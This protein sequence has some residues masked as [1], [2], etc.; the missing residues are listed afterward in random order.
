MHR[1]LAPLAAAL[2][3]AAAPSAR[4][5][6][7]TLDGATSVHALMGSPIRV[8]VEGPPDAPVSLVLD[9]T[10]GPTVV[11]GVSVPVGFSPAWAAVPV[12][13]L[14]ADGRLE[15]LVHAPSDP[16]F[17]QRTL[18]A[19]AVVFDPVTPGAFE[20]SNGVSL[21]LKDRDVQLAGRTLGSAPGFEYVRAFQEG[22]VVELALDTARYPEVVGRTAD[23]YLMAARSRDAWIADVGLDTAL[24]GPVT[25]E[26][27]AGPLAD[28]TLV[29]DTG[30]LSGDAGD[31]LGVGYDVVLDLNRDG[32]FNGD[33]LMDGY[34]DESG[35]YVVDDITLPGPHPVT[36]VIYSGGSWLGQD[37]YYPTD[38]D[39][40]GQLPLVV[41]SHGNGH[42]FQW[43]DHIGNHLASYGYIVMSHE[44]R[45]A[46]G[47]ESASTTTLTNTDYFLGN[48]DTIAGGVLDGH[49]DSSRITWIGHSRGGE[50]VVRAFDRVFDGDWV[51]QHFT[52]FDIALISSIAP[53]GFLGIGKSHPHGVDYHLWTGV[54]DSDVNGC[55][56]SDIAQT[57]QLHDRASQRRM[58]VSLYGV[59]HGGFH[60]G[61]GSL[62][63]QGP[64][65]LT[66]PQTHRFMRGYLLPLVKHVVDGNIPAKD[67][68]WRQWEGFRPLGAPVNPCLEVNLQYREG[69]KNGTYVVDDH[70]DNDDDPTLSSC[71]GAVVAKGIVGYTEGR[72][73][74]A[75]TDFTHDPS[76]PWN[77]FTY[78]RAAG[79]PRQSVFEFPGDATLEFQLPAGDRD[80]RDHAYLSFRACQATRHPYTDAET[81][82]T[83]FDVTLRDGAGRTSTLSIDAWGGG[84]E[85]PWPRL[86]CGVGAGWAN[87][88][89]TIR[90]RLTDFLHV[91]PA[92]DLGDLEA[93]VFGFGPS[94][95]SPVG[96]LGFDDV[97]LTVD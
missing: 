65:I 22:D 39:T 4:A 72:A 81:T 19:G 96:R 21:R 7:L 91:D 82:D 41:V 47:I 46:P 50:G 42:D 52:V 77:G 76:D 33:D 61:G 28:N 43:Y 78:A 15:V 86:T 32:R 31:D 26:F 27:T 29:L 14:G 56:A 80:V 59:G 25:H 83:V 87:E 38:V 71:G 63:A 20:A 48:L 8:A 55:A 6:D 51:P 57:F 75:N 68:L 24:A 12:G 36:E 73:N 54:A 44:N 60:A 40:M 67:Y 3:L 79:P 30:T 13:T 62:W 16:S 45:T 90:I 2:A 11:E 97:E 10:P 23:I 93:V 5:A 53:T 17:H 92:L 35:F 94:H 9:W 1:L 84:V 70:E 18:Y 49:V 88:Y 89:E 69:D 66:R 58:S 37:L 85:D 34:A 74:D 95:G 64:C